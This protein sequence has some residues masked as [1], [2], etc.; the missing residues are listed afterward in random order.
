MLLVD[1]FI[2]FIYKYNN[3]NTRNIMTDMAESLTLL[4]LQSVVY[5]ISNK[6]NNK[7]YIGKTN[8]IKRRIS[9]YKYM[10]CFNVLHNKHLQN[11]I[12]KYGINNFSFEILEEVNDNLLSER[13]IYWINQYQSYDNKKGYNKTFGGE[14][15]TATLEIRIKIASSLNGMKHNEEWIKNQSLS[16]LGLKHSFL[17][18]EKQSASH[19]KRFT[20]VNNILK[21]R[22]SMSKKSVMQL[23]DNG[24][25]VNEFISIREAERQTKI[26]S[27]SISRCCDNKRKSAGGF[28]WSYNK[29]VDLKL[30]NGMGHNKLKIIQKDLKNNNVKIWN[31]ISEAAIKTKSSKSA[32]IKC[33]K[34]KLKTCNNFMWE[35]VQ[36]INE[37]AEGK[38]SG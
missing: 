3:M 17:T 6:T 30:K 19:K 1:I 13:E 20:N 4:K 28:Y 14:G 12:N 15:L 5:K 7:V 22:I 25:I 38:I 37:I 24:N 2:V 32:I 21:H 36:P 27:S 11:A 35:Y 26:D 18:R 29:N 23:D 33:C 10:I 34:K 16:H 31:S 9:Q 8:N